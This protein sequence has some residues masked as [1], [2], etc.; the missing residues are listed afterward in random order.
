E[1]LDKLNFV[2]EEQ[3]ILYL[4]DNERYDEL[5]EYIKEFKLKNKIKDK[6]DFTPIVSNCI[7]KKQ[8]RA[9]IRLI[10]EFNLQDKI[11]L[12]VFAD[13]LLNLWNKNI[14]RLNLK[15]LLSISTTSP[16]LIKKLF[17][18]IS[19]NPKILWYPSAGADFRDII[20]LTKI[21]NVR[22]IASDYNLIHPPTLF[23]HTDTKFPRIDKNKIIRFK[24]KNIALKIGSINK[25]NFV[26][27]SPFCLLQNPEVYLLNFILISDKIRIKKPLI[28]FQLENTKFLINILLKHRVKVSYIILVNPGG[29]PRGDIYPFLPTLETEFVI[30]NR[31]IGKIT[32]IAQLI[33]KELHL[34]LR[35]YRMINLKPMTGSLWG[36]NHYI[37]IFKIKTLVSKTN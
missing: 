24:D 14:Q 15:N 16:Q 17:D 13:E 11:D 1:V 30:T 7:N 25:L 36:E 22:N 35:K 21:N 2:S 37:N 6:V 9:A 33:A 23:I 34:K 26:K 29:Y 3:K 28:Y 19:E 18:S 5:F 4:A 31:S 20:E 32:K 10:E 27:D 8:Y 12:L